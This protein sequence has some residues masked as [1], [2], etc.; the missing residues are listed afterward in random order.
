MNF[1]SKRKNISTATNANI[2]LTVSY[3]FSYARSCVQ[4]KCS[5]FFFTNDNVILLTK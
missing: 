2:Y 1:I 3:N 4:L 5:F